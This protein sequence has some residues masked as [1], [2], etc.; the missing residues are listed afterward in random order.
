MYVNLQAII[1]IQKGFQIQV[2]NLMGLEEE[3]LLK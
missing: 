3:H 2:D 1:I